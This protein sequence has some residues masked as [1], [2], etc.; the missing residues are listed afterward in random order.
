MKLRNKTA[1]QSI[2]RKTAV[3]LLTAILI[4]G[5]SLC[6][7]CACREE[8][9][10]PSPTNTKEE[11]RMIQLR[12][13]TIVRPETLSDSVLDAVFLLQD[14][15]F[16]IL[17]EEAKL[18]TDFEDKDKN[19]YEI[20]IGMTNREETTAVHKALQAG[21]YTVSFPGN[22]I[23]LLGQTDELTVLA[24]RAFIDRYLSG[25]STELLT[26]GFTDRAGEY[27]PLCDGSGMKYQLVYSEQ[28]GSEHYVDIALA[29]ADS[30]KQATKLE[31]IPMRAI[32]P[33]EDYRE[34]A[35]E[36]LIG[37][38]G[39]PESERFSDGLSYDRYGWGKEGNKIVIFGYTNTTLSLAVED[40][41]SYLAEC[42]YPT[43]KGNGVL[44]CRTDKTVMRQTVWGSPIPVYEGGVTLGGVETGTDNLTVRIDKTN[45]SEYLA[46]G[47]T[48]ENNGY[49]LSR[50]SRIGTVSSVTYEKNGEF[51]HVYYS[52]MQNTVRIMTGKSD[53]LMKDIAPQA[54][55]TD[56][57]ISQ[58]PLDQ[59][60]WGMYGMGYVITLP[61]GRFL[62][63][64]G[65]KYDCDDPLI[66]YRYLK[67]N[68]VRPDGKIV[69]AAWIITHYH[70][71]HYGCL[72]DFTDAYAKTGEIEIGQIIFGMISEE[73]AYENE[74]RP[75]STI[76]PDRSKLVREM[77][78]KW[79]GCEFLIPLTGGVY[80]IGDAKVE[81]LM[82]HTDWYPG[83]YYYENDT[84]TVFRVTLGEKS[85]M[86]LGDLE[87]PG[88]DLLM[89][90][91]DSAT[92]KS[93]V[94]QM[95]HHGKGA[96]VAL[97]SAIAAELY[98]YSVGLPSFE[99]H[100]VNGMTGKV[101][102]ALNLS[103]DRFY[104]YDSPTTEI[105]LLPYSGENKAG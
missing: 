27:I 53:M 22:R 96:N 86:F 67:A 5:I 10:Q 18:V 23:V 35:C 81:I 12:Q 68:N 78:D 54:P 8:R 60:N 14:R 90:M 56:G 77:A 37:R 84:S 20:L 11:N 15:L 32:L 31:D 75:N 102:A 47:K 82:T 58:T 80:H 64:D 17:G 66:L 9:E 24:I 61:D 89:S 69:I 72:R 42:T 50:Q 70:V 45:E 52:A 85:V 98:Y 36:I 51:V 83:H 87:S 63:V 92:L 25:G 101:M 16:E 7:L 65:G 94:V 104:H 73:E 41:V 30:L 4:C 2:G 44:C 43:G 46:Y 97:Y 91:Y 100:S 99:W 48:L 34:D 28:S 74:Y 71:D 93:Y 55:I 57:K 59:G 76:T 1:T 3:R 29:L 33:G 105:V 39:Y 79:T 62:L 26:E 19:G 38:V 13:Y 88:S 103:A 21:E 95:A 49:G 40:F 6:H